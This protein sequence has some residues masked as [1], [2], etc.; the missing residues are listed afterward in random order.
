MVL[1][2]G[3]GLM[4]VRV[5]M[6]MFGGTAGGRGGWYSASTSVCD[7]Q[8]DRRDTLLSAVLVAVTTHLITIRALE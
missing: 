2:L 8:R 4:L 1:V 5:L 3:L 7:H 6:M